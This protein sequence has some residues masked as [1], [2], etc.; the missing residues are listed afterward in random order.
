MIAFEW[1]SS[2]GW[3]DLLHS[4]G[5]VADLIHMVAELGRNFFEDLLSQVTLCD[6]IVELNELND[7]TTGGS[8]R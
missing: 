8:A 3:H 2:L 5:F 6:G 1:L 7:V 4:N